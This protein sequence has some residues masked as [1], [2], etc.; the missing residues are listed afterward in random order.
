[1]KADP[2]ENKTKKHGR[3]SLLTSMLVIF[4]SA[5]AASIALTV[6]L[7]SVMGRS[8]YAKVVAKGMVTQAR[9]L[10]EETLNYINGDISEDNYRF[11]TKSS[12]AEV[13]TLNSMLEPMQGG[14]PGPGEMMPD[15]PGGG[16]R[17]QG[18]PG[19][20]FDEYL[21]VCKALYPQAVADPYGEYVKYD[22]RLGVIAAKPVTGDDGVIHGAVFLIKPVADITEASKSLL[23]VLVIASVAAGIMML[24]PIYFISRW[25]TD[26]VKKLTGAASELSSGDY[27]IR[28]EPDGFHEVHELGIAFNS[29]SG[30]LQDNIGKLTLER[31]RLRAVLEGLG[32][33]IIAFDVDGNPTRC[34]ASA[35]ELLGGTEENIERI[36][37]FKFVS[38]AAK[39]VIATGGEHLGTFER[40]DR[41]IRLNVAAI[42]EESGSAAG[43]VALLMDMT[44][45][46]RLE[47]TRRD[48]VANVSHELRTPLA[49]I[50]G[51]ADMLNDGLVK[52]EEDKQRYYG[53]IQKES[54]RL[55]KLINDLLELSR[56]QSGGVAL[57]MTKMELY[58]LASDVAERFNES[59]RERGMTVRLEIPEGKYLANSN[60]DRVEQVLVSLTDNA[61]KH[62]EEGGEITIG[63]GEKDDKWVLFVENPADIERKD[64]ERLFERFYKADTAH[65]GEGT[66]LGLAITEEVLH[67]MGE[68]IRAD[69]EEG[70]IRFSF[71]VAKFK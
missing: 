31:N 50:R 35:A 16:E 36:P 15:K 59:A 3:V 63:L 11:M 33:G 34:N 42:E 8:V 1:M 23:I 70:R 66:G 53:Y 51:I 7:F 9:S 40:D 71:T 13:I 24:I 14:D 55:S 25:L 10:A 46:E 56:L 49:S 48:Y 54:I 64:L 57:K 12:E 52:S 22:P 5:L 45:A 6:I 20:H 2:N 4:I 18:N 44:E 69:Y 21:E 58:E 28:V 60:P 68:T 62:G 17:P 61:V 47:Q 41:V 38:D 37:E 29:L 27:S 43:A 26:P 32:E 67:L 19:G 30:S 65:T 39:K